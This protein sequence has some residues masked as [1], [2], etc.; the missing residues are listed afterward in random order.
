MLN[1][2][3]GYQQNA[4]TTDSA[5]WAGIAGYAKYDMS[6]TWSLI[7]RY[8]LFHDEAGFRTGLGT[9]DILYQ[10]LTLTSQ[11]QV[12][13]NLIARLEYRHDQANDAVFA[14][15]TGSAVNYQNTVAVEF[16]MPF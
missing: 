11:H 4:T 5:D 10:E 1:V 16:I 6:D 13:D 7:G 14:A 2:D 9:G 15:D 3:F 8:E 12:H